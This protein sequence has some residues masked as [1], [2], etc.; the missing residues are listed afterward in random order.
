MPLDTTPPGR[1]GRLSAVLSGTTV[2]LQWL[3]ALD[4][5]EV[6]SYVVARD[7]V[8]L[9]STGDLTFTDAGAAA[10]ATVLYT[11]SAVDATATSGRLPPSPSRFPTRSRRAPPPVSRPS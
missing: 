5:R 7:G 6:A 4:D 9:G 10:G 11:V 8:S 3:A 2:S 1:P